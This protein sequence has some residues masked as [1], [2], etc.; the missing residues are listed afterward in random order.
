[1]QYLVF[2]THFSPIHLPKKA[3]PPEYEP[4]DG[5]VTDE[6]ASIIGVDDGF[7]PDDNIAGFTY[8]DK[9][10]MKCMGKK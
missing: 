5:V 6:V 1:M 4:K 2:V 9:M 10:D 7:L 3:A 8:H